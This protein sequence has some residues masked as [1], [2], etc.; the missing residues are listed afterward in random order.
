MTLETTL[1]TIVQSIENN[2]KN[3]PI[4]ASAVTLLAASKG[5]DE[6][7]IDKA[8]ELGITDFGENRV[9]EA[10]GK[11]GA[12]KKRHP[13]IRLHLIGPLQSNKTDKA[14][15]LFDVIQ[16]IDRIKLADSLASQSSSFKPGMTFYIQVNIGQEPQKAGI[17]PSEADGLIEHCKTIGLP[18]V[19]LMCIPPHDQPP[20]PHFALLR[21]IALRHGLSGLSMGMSDDYTQAVRMGATVVR[22]GRALFGE[23]N[24]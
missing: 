19:G 7:V 4:A 12:L 24:S 15:E 20:A 16:T 10:E 9:Q 22:L 3:S 8:I 6:A 2:R 13:H 1:A 14:L 5:Q 21:D 11:W 23:R 17:I 18:I